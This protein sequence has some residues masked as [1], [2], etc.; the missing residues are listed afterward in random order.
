MA[1][2]IDPGPHQKL[3]LFGKTGSPHAHALR[4]FLHRS[5]IPF[6]W[7]EVENEEQAKAAGLRGE[8][9][10][11]VCIFSDSTRLEKLS[12]RQIKEKLGCSQICRTVTAI[13]VPPGVI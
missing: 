10:L 4:D 13:R 6:D 9:T 11:P 2:M 8:H 7:V 3:R 5:D 12:I 1:D